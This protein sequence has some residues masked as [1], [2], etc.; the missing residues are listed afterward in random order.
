LSEVKRLLA[1]D[2]L[3]L[4]STPNKSA[5]RTESEEKNQFH[6]SELEPAEFEGLLRRYFREITFLGQRIHSG[7]SIWALGQPK[8]NSIEEIA[9][10]H[11]AA[12]F[13]FIANDR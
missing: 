4:V 1:P 11:R 7:S 8:S 6:V 13:D 5:Y 10:E 12:E 2:G 3:F 9:V